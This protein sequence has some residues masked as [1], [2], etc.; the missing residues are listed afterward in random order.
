MTKRFKFEGETLSFTA[1][2]ETLKRK[3]A[4]IKQLI[5]NYQEIES[6]LDSDAYMARGNG[7]CET[8]YSEDF[9]DSRI[10]DLSRKAEQLETWIANF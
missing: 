10:D 2:L 3:L 1:D 8:K 5:N 9:I 4:E 7:F 6:D